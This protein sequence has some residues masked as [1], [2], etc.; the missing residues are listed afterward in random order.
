MTYAI[1]AGIPVPLPRATRPRISRQTYR[2]ADMR[3]GDSF[4]IPAEDGG[5]EA[6]R[7][8]CVLTAA[9]K[10]GVRVSTRVSDDGLRVW[11]LA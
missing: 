9:R 7:R 6:N 3:A 11:R 4:L 2:F 8:I 5:L 1:E 10:A